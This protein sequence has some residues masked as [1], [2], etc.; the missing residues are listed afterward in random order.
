MALCLHH[1]KNSFKAICFQTAMHIYFTYLFPDAAYPL[2]HLQG[3]CTLGMMPFPSEWLYLQS[4]QTNRPQIGGA[5]S[6]MLELWIVITI[7][8]SRHYPQ[9][10]GIVK[11]R[12]LSL[13][14]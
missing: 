12:S 2:L 1:S 7:L 10:H 5:D 13:S 3:I 6:G 14:H 9:Y 4:T 11:L 8:E